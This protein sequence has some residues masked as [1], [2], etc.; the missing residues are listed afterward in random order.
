MPVFCYI[1][2]DAFA[3]SVER[4]IHPEL[5]G[6]P[7]IV[8]TQTAER[9][10]VACASWDLRARGV[11]AGMPVAM[12]RRR[13]EKA[14]FLPPNPL[15]A[16]RA[17]RRVLAFL[18]DHGPVVELDKIDGFFI[19]MSGCERWMARPALDWI[20]LL[21]RKLERE[22]RLPVSGGIGANKLVARVA[23]RVAKPGGIMQV[24]PGGE[25]DFLVPVA[26]GLLPGVGAVTRR[27]LREFGVHTV[28]QLRALGEET[29][30]RLYGRGP[31][32]LLW[33]YAHGVC[34][35]PVIATPAARML[36]FDHAFDEDTSRPSD[37]EQGVILLAQRLCWEMRGLAVVSCTARISLIYSDGHHACRVV[38]VDMATS[39]EAQLVRALGEAGLL[40]FSRRVRVRSVHLAAVLHEQKECQYDF[41]QEQ[42]QLRAGRLHAA[43]DQVRARH[44]FSALIQAGG[45]SPGRRMK[46]A[47]ATM[48]ELW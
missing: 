39:D 22:T 6:R 16:E 32:S 27:E 23:A 2:I 40:A 25:R 10:L 12:A 42:K 19:D 3:V 13:A 4:T 31:G 34:H 30:L 28:G 21:M 44:G 14:L 33:G 7:V 37:L 35:E 17:S 36:E 38:K 46:A 43:I 45:A 15:A 24:L 9:G 5:A 11:R 47:Q 26:V 8:T 20:E 18:Q 1:D 41:F 29:L 48:E